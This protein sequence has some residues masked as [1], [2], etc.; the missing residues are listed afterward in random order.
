L[1]LRLRAGLGPGLRLRL[2]A[3]LRLRTLTALFR[4]IEESIMHHGQRIDD[5]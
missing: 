2:R 3:G 5:A 1:R 4:R